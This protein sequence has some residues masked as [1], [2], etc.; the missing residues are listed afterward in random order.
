MS[1]GIRSRSL[2]CYAVAVGMVVSVPRIWLLE[3]CSSHNARHGLE[4]QTMLR[5]IV[6]TT[7]LAAVLLP[8]IATAQ[9]ESAMSNWHPEVNDFEWTVHSDYRFNVCYDPQ[10][11]EDFQ[12]ALQWINHSYNI[13]AA[14]YGIEHPIVRRGTELTVEI[15]FFPRQTSYASPS[16]AANF[17]QGNAAEV[18][19]LTASLYAEGRGE[20]LDSFAKVLVHE[21][22]NVLFYDIDPTHFQLPSWIREGLSEYEGWMTTPYNM[23][24]M[25]GSS[26]SSLPQRVDRKDI[27]FG[28]FATS[29]SGKTTGFIVSEVY[30]AGA[31]VVIVLAE[32]FGEGIHRQLFQQPLNDVLAARRSGGNERARKWNVFKEIVHWLDRYGAK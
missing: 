30:F 11:E 25:K 26:R 4:G 24:L 29:L 5:Y 1:K 20:P 17:R 19:L 2:V 14:K 15:F 32:Q 31:V 6:V 13:G 21:M 27:A 3:S 16:R 9:C 12:Y 18:H 10:F 22:M 8:G 23:G 28:W 7:A